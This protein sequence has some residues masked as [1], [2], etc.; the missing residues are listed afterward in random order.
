MG[1]F[2]LAAFGGI[3]G[4]LWART[5]VALPGHG[6][7]G[8]SVSCYL[9]DGFAFIPTFGREDSGVRRMVEP[10]AV[11]PVT[12]GEAL[13]Q[14][15]RQAIERGEPRLPTLDRRRRQVALPPLPRLAGVGSWSSFY[16]G[17]TIWQIERRGGA[18]RIT[19]KLLDRA[20]RRWIADAT[21]AI[22][23]P[24]DTDLDALCDRAAA[25]FAAESPMPKRQLQAICYL[26]RGIVYVP[27]YGRTSTGVHRMIEPI[28]AI[29]LQ[30]TDEIR[31]AI[32]DR[33]RRGNPMLGT[34]PSLR[35]E[36]RD[37]LL[38]LAGAESWT[39][40]DRSS[41]GS[42]KIAHDED[43]FKITPGRL[44]SKKGGWTTDEDA[45]ISLPTGT[46]V[47]AACDCLIDMMRA[48]VPPESGILEPHMPSAVEQLRT[49]PE[50]EPYVVLPMS[51]DRIDELSD[52]L[53]WIANVEPKDAPT[54][55]D[56]IKRY[57]Y[58]HGDEEGGDALNRALDEA[59]VAT[60]LLERA[61]ILDRYELYVQKDWIEEHWTEW[62]QPTASSSILSSSST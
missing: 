61:K 44:Y 45:A 26:R 55:R 41:T 34:E 11:V 15:I 54:I 19:P 50:E 57:Y 33:F 30:N 14:A 25:I 49:D 43:G 8:I 59:L 24:P 60:H 35:D 4:W 22:R 21:N 53:E 2:S 42:W 10:V 51:P 23:L 28:A 7:S 6:V 38:V 5:A 58:D 16:E 31:A 12:D 36:K 27:S 32:E 52:F 20:S 13:H 62:A 1:R 9:R 37:A 56:E 47:E 39:A 48:T 29:P 3:F 40:F 18:Y 17:V 46:A